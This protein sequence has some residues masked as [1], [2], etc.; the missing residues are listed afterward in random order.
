MKYLGYLALML[1]SCRRARLT[2]HL[3]ALAVSDLLNFLW[4]LASAVQ[5]VTLHQVFLE[6]QDITPVFQICACYIGDNFDVQS[7]TSVHKSNFDTAQSQSALDCQCLCQY[8]Q[9]SL[10]GRAGGAHFEY[11]ACGNQP[12]CREFKFES[13]GS[14]Y[15]LHYIFSFIFLCVSWVKF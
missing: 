15:S 11:V 13:G 6:P 9:E 3:H 8:L 10:R 12:N 4:I 1:S 2:W 7:C 14:T 5:S